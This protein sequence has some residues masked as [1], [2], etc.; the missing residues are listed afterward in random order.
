MAGEVTMKDLQSLQGFVNKQIAD[1]NKKIGELDKK[2]GDLSKKADDEL[3]WRKQGVEQL[4]KNDAELV[5]VHGLQET[6]IG[7]LEKNVAELQKVVNQHAG[8]ISNKSDKLF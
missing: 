4:N 2:I 7:N 6:K 8:V 1:V 3:A 5:R